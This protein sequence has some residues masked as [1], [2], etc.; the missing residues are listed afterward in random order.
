M[1]NYILLDALGQVM[2]D[3]SGIDPMMFEDEDE[4]ILEAERL[5]SSHADR[6]PGKELKLTLTACE[7]IPRTKIELNQEVKVTKNIAHREVRDD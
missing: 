3:T 6:N 4:A 7:V 5:L 2:H 1:N